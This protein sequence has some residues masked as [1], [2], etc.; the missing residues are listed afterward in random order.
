MDEELAKQ[1]LAT[2]RQVARA[3]SSGDLA[4]GHGAVLSRSQL[5]HLDDVREHYPDVPTQI[6]ACER[7]DW[8]ACGY[9]LVNGPSTTQVTVVARTFREVDGRWRL[10]NGT[11]SM[12]STTRTPLEMVAQMQRRPRL[13]MPD[14]R[15]AGD[16]AAPRPSADQLESRPPWLRQLVRTFD[17]TPPG[18]WGG[19]LFST[20]TVLRPSGA[21]GVP[22]DDAP[23][24][25]QADL[26]LVMALAQEAATRMTG[27]EV[28]ASQAT[29]GWEPFWIART[30]GHD[31]RSLS[32]PQVIRACGGSLWPE[33][34]VLSEP[35]EAG[36]GFLHEWLGR[37]RGR[38]SKWVSALRRC[39]GTAAVTG[40][41]RV[42][43]WFVAE[44]R[45]VE[46]AVVNFAT[47]DHPCANAIPRL[48]LGRTEG[49]SVAGAV[50][51]A[52]DNAG[53]FA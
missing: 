17:F 15:T 34:Q 38:S 25:D 43:R 42:V 46:T 21:L 32:A 7:I 37:L 28:F 48:F 40:Y 49:G 11:T 12:S 52:V 16:L 51:V 33:A 8:W 13:D 53:G 14:P 5:R 36:L 3:G 44:P 26:A 31:L 10:L 9:F 30:D 20:R 22:E 47:G 18:D 1:L 39:E 23:P 50:G 19:T 29:T 41:A 35:M 45:F 2:Y 4:S 6:I 24:P 27:L